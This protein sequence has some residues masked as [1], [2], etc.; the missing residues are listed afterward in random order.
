VG[1]MQ[2][3]KGASGERE[4][5]AL[6][7]EAGFTSA[8]R[9]AQ[10]QAGTG[11]E[12]DADVSGIGRL[13]VEVKR[14]ARVNVQ[15]CMRELLATER[16]GFVRALFHRSNNGPWLV[17]LEA[18]ELLKLERDALRLTPPLGLTPAGGIVFRRTGALFSDPLQ[19]TG[20]VE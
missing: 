16:P 10:M 11:D 13:W 4:V 5:V 14:H 1:A 17:T 12:L 8:R 7:K 19:D 9:T 18:S 3:R 2:R 20:T 15:G 6:A